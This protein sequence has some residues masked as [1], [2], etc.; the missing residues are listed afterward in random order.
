MRHPDLDAEQIITVAES[1]VPFHAAA[2]WVRVEDEPEPADDKSD[3]DDAGGETPAREQNKSG[4]RA[5][6]A[7]KKES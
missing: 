6:A 2:G 3:K 4:P 1:A 7:K 5:S